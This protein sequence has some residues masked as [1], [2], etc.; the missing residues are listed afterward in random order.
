[1]PGM[2]FSCSQAADITVA[3][4]CLSVSVLA[5]WK[6]YWKVNTGAFDVSQCSKISSRSN[7]LLLK[8]LLTLD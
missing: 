6:P 8:H 3:F 5:T 4:V 2:L 1:M 7:P